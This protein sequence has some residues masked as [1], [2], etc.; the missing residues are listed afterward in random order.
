MRVSFDE[1]FR[2][3]PNGSFTLKVLVIIGGVSM[4]PGVAFTPGVS[5]FGIDITQY[6]G[7]DLDVEKLPDG[8][9]EI[10]GIGREYEHTPST[11]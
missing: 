3:N 4:G 7:H 11:P 2:S 5:F 8:S 10:K 6:A 9:I 1:V